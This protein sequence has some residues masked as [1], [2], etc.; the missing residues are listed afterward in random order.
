MVVVCIAMGIFA[1]AIF[2]SD[3][4]Q[5][6]GW[7]NSEISSIERNPPGGGKKKEEL[8]VTIGEQKDNMMIEVAEKEFSKQELE[9]VFQ[10][11]EDELE[12]RILGENESLDEVRSRL[13]LIHVLPDSGI[14]VDWRLDNYNLMNLQ[15]EIH[16]EE[17]TESGEIIRLDALLSYKDEKVQHTFYAHIYPP[18]LTADESLKKK[19]ECAVEEQDL[20]S[21]EMKQM[22]LPDTV[23]GKSVTWS[24]V[25]RY[26][27]L[28]ILL[29]GMAFALMLYVSEGEKEKEKS[30]LRRKQLELDYSEIVSCFTLY[31][32]AGMTA[33]M[34][35]FKLAK[36]YENREKKK[37]TRAA[38]EEMIYTMHEIQ[39]G[40]SESECYERFGERCEL[41]IYRKFGVLLSQ[42]LKKGTKGFIE[43]LKQESVD[44]FEERKALAKIQGEEVGTKIL[45]PMFLMLVSV[46]IMIVFPAFFSIQI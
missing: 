23:E 44:A 3:N 1:V 31:L 37:E 42:N 34:A 36:D 5:A 43:L 21:K 12:K 39:S 30:K 17:L 4:W 9:E 16:Q 40:A 18:N 14:Q 13:N 6:L 8:K 26:R 32:G 7:G 11:A 27:S 22:P 38:Y 15:G 29:L 33:R 20:A 25:M 2:L 45:L 46:L 35:W 10:K 28:A 41:S 19:L 24:P